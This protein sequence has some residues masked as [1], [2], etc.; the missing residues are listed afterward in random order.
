V[1]NTVLLERREA[2]ILR[3]HPAIVTETAFWDYPPIGL[4]TRCKVGTGV[5]NRETV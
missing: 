4:L 1:F 3:N 2:P 5:S